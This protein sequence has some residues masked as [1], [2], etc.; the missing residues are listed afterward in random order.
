M[1]LVFKKIYPINKEQLRVLKEYLDKN[2]K[3]GFIYKSKSLARYPLF[4]VTKKNT[5]KL[6]LVINYRQLNKIT[7]KN[8]YPLPLIREIID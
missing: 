3:K 4:F 6:R 7:I 8:Q 1:T 5:I 2:L